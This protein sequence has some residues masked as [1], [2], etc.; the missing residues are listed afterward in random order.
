MLMMLM[1][2]QQAMQDDAIQTDTTHPATGLKCSYGKISSPLT[3]IS[4]TEP[5]RP[6]IWTHRKF[7]TKDF[8]VRRDLGNRASPVNRGHPGH[9]G[10]PG[11]CEE[12]LNLFLFLPFSLPSPSSDLKLPIELPSNMIK[13][14]FVIRFVYKPC[15]C[16][17]QHVWR[18]LLYRVSRW[19]PISTPLPPPPPPN[20]HALSFCLTPYDTALGCGGD[21]VKPENL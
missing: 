1:Q 6:F 11:S 10:Q 12:A 4:A 7:Y 16:P 2:I 5:A 3:E 9:P 21:S 13:H 17:R 18:S 14:T 8:E 15:H 19:G 20:E